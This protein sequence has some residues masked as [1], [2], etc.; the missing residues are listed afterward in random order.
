MKT[1][2]INPKQNPEKEEQQHE[3]I[4]REFD[5]NKEQDKIHN[6]EEEYED[7]E[8]EFEDNKAQSIFHDGEG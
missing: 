8:H 7:I 5:V 1:K 6:G 4:E 2:H 3:G